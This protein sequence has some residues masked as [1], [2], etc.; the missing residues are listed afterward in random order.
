MH[1]SLLLE[2]KTHQDIGQLLEKKKEV[3][4]SGL[5]NET[6]KAL[7]VAQLLFQ[8]PF[9]T[10]L[11]TEDEERRGLLRHWCGF[12]GVQCEE[13]VGSQEEHVSPSVLQ[14]LL[15]LQ[16]GKWSGVLLVAREFWDRKIPSI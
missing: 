5:S 15:L 16:T 13:V 7:L 3:T 10:L 14:K 8:K 6:A 2:Q 1:P 9:P 4:V 12:F 11:V